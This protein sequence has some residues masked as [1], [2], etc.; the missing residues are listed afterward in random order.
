LLVRRA[1]LMSAPR[2][3]ARLGEAVTS[4]HGTPGRRVQTLLEASQAAWIKHYRPD[5]NSPNSAIS[6][7]LK[8]E[9]AATLLD[10]EIRRSTENERSLDDVM[11]LL[12]KR[13][14][15]ERGVPEDGVEKAASEVAGT[16]LSA[17]FN[18][19]IRS[20]EELDYSPFQHVGLE[21]RFRVKESPTDRGGSGPR[22]KP[23]ELKAKGWLGAAFKGGSTIACVLE[24][25]PA[26]TG[27]LYADDEIIALDG[28]R[29]DGA[30][31]LAR[32]EEKQPGEVVRITLLRQDRLLEVDVKLE[33]KPADAAYLARVDRPSDSQKA[34]Y[35][36]W[37]GAPWDEPISNFQ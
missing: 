2:Y 25:S 26:M 22:L 37:L 14:A 35:F 20:T 13:Y 18:R 29:A 7:Y 3:L 8:G 19:A 28:Y 30:T 11:R 36:A 34:A 10:L 17:F 24:G 21:L 4:L 9:I 12:W 31:L 15:D 23:G 33:N 5:E 32:C 27:G 6:Y 16:D 1:G